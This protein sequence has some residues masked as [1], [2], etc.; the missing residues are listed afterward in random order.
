M[1]RIVQSVRW[2]LQLWHALILL[3]VITALCLV[4]HH[5]AQEERT[6]RV[7]RELRYFDRTMFRYLT[8]NQAPVGPEVIRERLR[9][10]KPDGSMPEVLKALF[11]EGESGEPYCVAWDEQGAEVFRSANAPDDLKA[12]GCSKDGYE[13]IRTENGRRE[14]FRM[15]PD[16]AGIAI[17]KELGRERDELARLTWKLVLCGGGIWSLGLIGGWWLAGRAIKPI[18]AIAGT[19]S[20]IANGNLAERI[21]IADT[22]N[23]LGRLSQ[24]LNETFDR[25]QTAIDRQKQFIADA[26]HELRTPVSVILCETQRGLKRERPSQEYKDILD[27]CHLASERMRTLVESLLTLARQDD[28]SGQLQ[29]EPCDLSA[30]AR[31]SLN[32]LKP[33]AEAHAIRI[34]ADLQP[35]TVDGDPRA[36][37]L[38]T[39]NLISNAIHHQPSGGSVNVRVSTKDGH[40]VL[41]VSDTGPG[42]APEHL[43][44]LFDRFYRTDKARGSA[45]GHSGLGLAIVKAIVDR[46]HGTVT[47]HSEP[48]QGATF[49]V[50]LPVAV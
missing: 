43:P 11:R 28:T 44:H 30:I 26:S 23:E 49:T 5:V 8:S 34:E 40:A 47:V 4:V 20:R 19:A 3:A 16:N 32:L 15:M 22:D 36:L 46:H 27:T 50:T 24:V 9:N 14:W 7:D 21:D 33:L 10:L 25:L 38:V 13:F 6:R 45:G 35:A 42:I 37:P 1:R 2:R 18:S 39:A 12:P 41:E 31:E 48:G 29:S 17:G